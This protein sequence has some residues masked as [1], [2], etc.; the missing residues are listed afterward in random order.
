M[1]RL[2]WIAVVGVG[3][4]RVYVGAQ[5]PVD[6]VGGAA[7]GWVIGN[8]IVMISRPHAVPLAG[9]LGAALAAAGRPVG[10]LQALKHRQGQASFLTATAE[11]TAVHVAVIGPDQPG[12]DWLWRAW[13]LLAF[14]E[15]D[16]RALPTPEHQVDRAA[17]HLLRSEIAEQGDPSVVPSLIATGTLGEGS[18][19]IARRWIDGQPL[20]AVTA[21]S[22]DTLLS[23]W[24]QL[25][26]LHAAGL[27]HGSITPERLIV[28]PG[29]AV[30]LVGLGGGEAPATPAGRARDVAE[31]ALALAAA[32]GPDLAVAAAVD[33]IGVERLREALPYLQPLALSTNARRLA[34]AHRGLLEALRNA[35]GRACGVTP[36]PVQRPFRVAA[37]NVMPLIVLFLAVN[38]LLPQVTQAAGTASVLGRANWAWIAAT[39]GAALGTY[40]MAAANWVAAAPVRLAVG[41]T[42][43]VQFAAA[44]TNRLT[45][46]GLGGMATN[47]GY[48]ERAGASRGEAVSAA[49]GISA[50]GFVVHLVAL[51]TIAPLLGATGGFRFSAPDLADRWPILVG[52]VVALAAI[53]AAEWR[54][55]LR[56]RFSRVF[57]SMWTAVRDTLARPRRAVALLAGSL[58]VNLFYIAALVASVR[59]YGGTLPP[60]RVAA[61]YL[62]ASAVAAV[63]P[64]PGGLGALEAAMVAGFGAAGLTRPVALA[65]VISYRLVTFWLPVLPGA[66]LWRVLRRRQI[67]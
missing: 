44:F 50:A 25:E 26:R 23:A 18:A 12:R 29:G 38:V 40:I 66:L 32:S 63:A 17:H 61:V 33:R 1:R 19:W 41:R 20:Y 65:A 6:V 31:L 62:G 54:R 13:R 3:L 59:A 35:T 47:V 7:L 28:T 14:R 30:R 8:A 34:S 11:G 2:A 48:L 4:A 52:I 57:T 24:E 43:A 22:K 67:V 39:F 56:R 51:A 64:T 55:R 37:R 21:L 16:D 60:A 27:T 42:F 5:F 45:P 46:A 15:V 58:G 10:Q 53:G 49:A 36:P 9:R